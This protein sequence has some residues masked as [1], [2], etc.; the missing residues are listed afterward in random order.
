MYTVLLLFLY[1]E[2]ESIEFYGK[3]IA[4]ISMFVMDKAY[5]II[6]PNYVLLLAIFQLYS[7]DLCYM[8]INWSAMR[9]PST[10]RVTVK[11]YHLMFIEYTSP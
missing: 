4:L 6:Y 8:W 7:S 9:K 2:D 3:S 11:L 10:C 1:Y 5:F